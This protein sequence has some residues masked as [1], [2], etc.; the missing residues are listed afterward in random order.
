[1]TKKHP[2]QGCISSKP[3]HTCQRGGASNDQWCLQ[4]ERSRRSRRQRLFLHP[5]SYSPFPRASARN[6]AKT[7]KL[8]HAA[9]WQMHARRSSPQVHIAATYQPSACKF[10]QPLIDTHFST[11]PSIN[12][13]INPSCLRMP[14]PGLRYYT[15]S[16]GLPGFPPPP[17]LK[18]SKEFQGASVWCAMHNS[19]RQAMNSATPRMQGQARC[20]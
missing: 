19:Y 12:T 16:P 3:S 4:K 6:A 13:H 11:M 1:M 2:V 7:Q 10:L 14:L 9:E 18:K 20:S 17:S 5:G 15:R 8:L